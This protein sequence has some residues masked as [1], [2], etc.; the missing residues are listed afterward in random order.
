MKRQQQPSNKL[1]ITQDLKIKKMWL[2]ALD[3]VSLN[4]FMYGEL[5]D[6]SCALC[7]YTVNSGLERS[8]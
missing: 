8:V 5:N 2:K 4:S 7:M 6:K 3:E 1:A